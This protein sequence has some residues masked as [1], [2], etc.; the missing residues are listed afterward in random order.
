[1]PACKNVDFGEGH[2]IEARELISSVCNF[3]HES[4]LK[5]VFSNYTAAMFPDLNGFAAIR[6]VMAGSTPAQI[7]A[8]INAAFPGQMFQLQYLYDNRNAVF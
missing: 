7:R 8:T 6:D 3:L 2:S 5:N 4:N 1:M